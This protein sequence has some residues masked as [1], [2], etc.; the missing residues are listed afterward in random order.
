MSNVIFARRRST[1]T[2]HLTTNYQVSHVV[3]VGAERSVIRRVCVLFS[4]FLEYYNDNN[5][6]SV[7][8]ILLRSI[9][10]CINRTFLYV[11]F[12]SILQLFQSD[13]PK[14]SPCTRPA[15]DLNLMRLSTFLSRRE[16]N[17]ANNK[18]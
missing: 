5:Y 7:I 10:T 11:T 13:H 1:V 3:D 17:N 2:V 16:L 4:R 12:D 18:R 6:H 15:L 8:V 9:G 14:P